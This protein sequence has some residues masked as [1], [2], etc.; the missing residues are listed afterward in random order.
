MCVSYP[1]DLDTAKVH[2]VPSAI[3]C[4]V[5]LLTCLDGLWKA[6]ETLKKQVQTTRT[7]HGVHPQSGSIS[8][9]ISV[10]SRQFP[11]CLWSGLPTGGNLRHQGV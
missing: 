2:C 10:Y 8:S 4:V 3:K 11:L 7:P 9:Q 6:F 1:A 5:Y